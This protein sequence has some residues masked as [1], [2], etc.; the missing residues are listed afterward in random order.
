MR[1]QVKYGDLVGAKR[2]YALWDTKD[3]IYRFSSESKSEVIEQAQRWNKLEPVD[4]DEQTY[5]R[6]L[7]EKGDQ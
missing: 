2:R 5:G 6:Q 3:H 1:Y 7:A 4:G